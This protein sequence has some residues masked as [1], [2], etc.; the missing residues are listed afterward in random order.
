MN[1]QNKSSPLISVVLPVYN[2]SRYIEKAVRSI[3][4]QTYRNIEIIC[5]DDASTDHSYKIIRILSSNDKRIKAYRLKN[6]SG[7][8]VTANIA[9]QKAK[10]KFIARMD[11]DDIM[12]RD[13]LKKQENFLIANPE[14]I[15]VGGQCNRIDEHGHILGLK[16]F[17]LDH[18]SIKSL[19]FRA[20]PIQ[21]PTLMI[22][23]TRLPSNFHW[24]RKALVIGEDYDLYYRLMQYGKLANL[25][26]VVLDYREHKNNL[27]LSSQKRTF[28]YIWKSRLIALTRYGYV[29]D[30]FSVINVAIQTILVILLPDRLL[31]PLHMQ[32]RKFFSR[33]GI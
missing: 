22:N 5:V 10:G 26:S 11:A 8:S 1:K 24:Y 12:L 4:K 29:P 13:R 25:S 27:T 7:A 14:I 33:A 32:T 3:Q 6:H 20:V 15:A 17:P 21:Q 19:L 31:Y 9:I 30:I 23:K 18:A 16:S 28:W 2:A